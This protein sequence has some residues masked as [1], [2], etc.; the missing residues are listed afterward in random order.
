M[1]ATRGRLYRLYALTDPKVNLF[2]AYNSVVQG[3][4]LEGDSLL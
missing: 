1:V 2:L 4:Y 3:S